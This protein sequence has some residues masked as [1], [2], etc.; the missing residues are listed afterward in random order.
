MFNVTIYD[1]KDRPLYYFN[2]TNGPVV[3]MKGYKEPESI[4]FERTSEKNGVM[5]DHTWQVKPSNY[6][7]EGDRIQLTMPAPVQFTTATKAFGTSYW[8]DGELETKLSD[9]LRT[10]D[11]VVV[12]SANRR[13]QLALEQ[14]RASNVTAE[15]EY[16]SLTSP[17]G[18]RS[19]QARNIPSGAIIN[20]RITNVTNP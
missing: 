3:V 18:R 2:S 8:L 12:L 16:G 6:L 4:S 15:E 17:A 13:R 5:G 14:S 9:N 1:G 11:I 7:E 19:L 20:I 10:I